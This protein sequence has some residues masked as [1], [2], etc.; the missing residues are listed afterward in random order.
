MHLTSW[1]CIAVALAGIVLLLL[2]LPRL[3]PTARLRR[4]LRKTHGRIVSKAR[5]PTV[6][7]SVKTPKE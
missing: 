6:K 7:F 1:I 2:F 3:T 4:R 5:G